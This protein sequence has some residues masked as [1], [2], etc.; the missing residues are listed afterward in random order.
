MNRPDLPL[1]VEPDEL[2]Q[3]IGNPA[4]LIVDLSKPGSYS[5][6]HVPG[7]VHLEYSE[8]VTSR[9]PVMGLLPDA[10][11]LSD[12]LSYIGATP[13]HHI[14]AYDDEGGAKAC[15]F[16]WTL[17]VIGHRHHALLNG[18]LHA[19][20]NENHATNNEDVEPN[21][22]R[23]A[24]TITPAAHVDKAYVLASLGKPSVVLLDTRS[25]AEFNGS[26]KRASRGGHIPGAINVDW[27]RA[28]D[29]GNNMR[30]R[31]AAELRSM[32][33]V[34]GVTRDKEIITYCQTHHRSS[35]TYWL[36]KALGYSDVKGYPGAWSEWGNAADTPVE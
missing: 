13:D 33:E 11:S 32:Y 29:Q 4:L 20:L 2:Q 1:V 6:Y 15:R 14:V 28:I 25:E 31:P 22:T 3:H 8:I 34:L 30:L 10:A 18:G 5:Q 9:P 24:A 17:D 27:V 16:L 36:L 23:Y 7:A 19:W 21:T 35:H 12:T 26:D